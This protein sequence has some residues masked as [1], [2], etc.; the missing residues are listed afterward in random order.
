MIERKYLFS[1]KQIGFYT[2]LFLCAFQVSAQKGKIGVTLF[3]GSG[4]VIFKN[5]EDLIVQYEPNQMLAVGLSGGY[6]VKSLYLEGRF[7]TSKINSDYSNN[8]TSTSLSLDFRNLQVT[9]A[10]I[11]P[12]GA[13]RA[14]VGTGVGVGHL[15][16]GMQ[17]IG[18]NFYDVMELEKYNKVAVSFLGEAGIIAKASEHLDIN[19]CL[20]FSQGITNLEKDASQT[21]HIRTYGIQSTLYYSF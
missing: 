16:F 11:S 10:Y 5:S 7:F 1:L 6:E 2:L 8:I 9:G 15:K 20:A 3:G 21:T 12:K 13:I 14:K 4:G 17:R 18:S 19:L